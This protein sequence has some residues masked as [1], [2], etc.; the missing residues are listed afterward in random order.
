MLP[1]YRIKADAEEIDT[2]VD[3]LVADSNVLFPECELKKAAVHEI[4]LKKFREER[5]QQKDTVTPRLL[6]QDETDTTE[7]ASESSSSTDTSPLPSQL[8]QI[9]QYNQYFNEGE[10]VCELV[11]LQQIWT[12]FFITLCRL[13]RNNCNKCLLNLTFNKLFLLS[14]T[15]NC[16]CKISCEKVCY[17]HK[18]CFPPPP[19]TSQNID[20]IAELRRFCMV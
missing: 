7:S 17:D 20:K 13:Q 19:N 12:L 14:L 18:V 9:R 5:R 1:N 8:A 15:S 10:L 2:F 11:I 3:K 6:S 16:K 4:V